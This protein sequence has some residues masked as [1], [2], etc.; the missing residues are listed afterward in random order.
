MYIGLFRRQAVLLAAILGAWA[1]APRAGPRVAAQS[2]GTSDPAV[3]KELHWRNIGPHRASR[4]KA[5][6]GVPGKPHTFYIG[7]VNGG[8]WK[9]TDAGRTWNPLFDDQPTGSIGALAVAPSDPRVIYVGTGESQ[10]RPD[11]ATGDGMYKSTDEGRTWTHLGLRDSQQIAQVVVDPKNADRLFVAALGH[12]YGPNTERG[13]FR[14][15]DGG[16]NFE[17]V[18]YKDEN[19][20]GVDVV[21]DPANPQVVYA[22]LWQARQGPWENGDFR[23]PGSG[24]FKSTDGGSTWKPLTKGLPT[25]D[26]DRLGRIGVG[27]AP[28]RPSRLFLV[29]EARTKSGIYRSDDSGESWTLVNSDERVVARPSDAT[30]IRVHPANPDVVIVPTVV[31]W[32]STD[33]GRTFTGFRGA[34]GGDDYQRA[35]FNPAN[36][37]II[38][39]TSDQGAIIT[40]NGGESWSSWYNQPT[41]AF[42]HVST[43]TSFP[44]RVCSGQ[45]E[46]GSVCIASRGDAGAITFRDW[47]PVGV[48]EYGY[49]APD[50]LDPDIV[51]G[52]KVSRWDRRTGQVQQVGPKPV[53]DPNY[54]VVRTMPVLFSPLNPR[55]LFFASNVVWQTITGGQSWEQISQDLTR[56]T[57][58]TPAN[59]GVYASQPEAK[60]TQRG[61]VYTIAPSYVDEQTIWAGTDDGLIHVTRDGGRTWTNVTPPEL[62]PWMKVSIVDASHFDANAAY[63]AINT[64]RLDDLRPHIYRTTDGG[65]TWIHITSGI[66][67]GGIINVVREDAKRRGLLFAGSE[68]AVYVS[69]DN[70]G[71]WQSLRINMPATSIR[72]LVIK[73]DDLVVGTHGRSF[74]I[75]D[76]ITPLRQ[77]ADAPLTA[78]PHLFAP[79]RATRV[80]WNLNTDTPLPPDEPAGQNP[81][82]GAILNYWLPADAKS[83]TLEI[84]DEAG[85]AI[86]R[87][88]SEDPPEPLVE[89]RNIPDYW[90]RPPQPLLKTRGLHRF[91][92]DLHHE[93]P[94]VT[95]FSYP[96]AAIRGD[97]A[98]VPNGSWVSPGRFTVR[99]SVDG[100]AHTAPLDVR[101]DPRVKA[102]AADIR[103]QYTLSRRLDAALRRVAPELAAAR[104]R[105]EA[106]AARAQELQRLSATLSQLFGVIE[107]ADVAPTSQ[108][109]AA[110]EDV[111]AAVDRALG[112]R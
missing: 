68:Q 27:I 23:G 55:K 11:L 86:R 30:D 79:Q 32:K 45:Q 13:I 20:G 14:S 91:V 81:P 82:D 35:W 69:F 106:G 21:L 41:A 5:L 62:K 17:R 90:I 95:S 110:V 37:D 93:R 112:V 94:A 50:P 54:R 18:L 101:M 43:D 83:V 111:L 9:T 60:P 7:V 73:D 102:S 53:R 103:Q 34:P 28:S 89:G 107:G 12:P 25:W 46:S 87:Y 8:V 88:T 24:L 72:D 51:Y 61:V 42:Y 96:I 6:D 76:D 78:G 33:G 29:V 84:V 49:V 100:Q 47:S 1:L 22:A 10:Q 38:A 77:W 65:K 44:Y 71:R 52:G 98:R 56:A 80:R 3:F 66:P 97:T 39:L 2:T 85:S 57:W 59:V 58:E 70:G 40:L 48:E 64:L 16:R 19:T 67:D 75:L 63:A 105:G 31:T 4:T 15:T 26:A 108:A 99:L 104:S 36:P 109:V 92:W 74:W